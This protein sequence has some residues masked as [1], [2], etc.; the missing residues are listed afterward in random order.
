MS[1]AVQTAER[2]TLYGKVPPPGENVPIHVGMVDIPDGA[3]SDQELREVVRGL[4]NGRAAGAT[5]LKAEHIKVWLCEVVREE[6]EEATD[7]M[8]TAVRIERRARVIRVL[9]GNGGSSLS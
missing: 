2:V 3:P 6:E 7:P 9:E 4:R 5:G 1:L 8:G